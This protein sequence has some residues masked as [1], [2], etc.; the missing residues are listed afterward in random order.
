[1]F[2]REA[3]QTCQFAYRETALSGRMVV[4]AAAAGDRVPER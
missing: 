2:E 4:D 3:L 1:M